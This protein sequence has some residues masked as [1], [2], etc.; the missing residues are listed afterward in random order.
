MH[1]SGASWETN[2]PTYI[3]FSHVALS[4]LT[5]NNVLLDTNVFFLSLDEEMT[6][7]KGSSRFD[8][9]QK[10]NTKTPQKHINMISTILIYTYRDT[11]K[12][13]RL[14]VSMQTTAAATASTA[15]R[16]VS[17]RADVM[18]VCLWRHRCPVCPGCVCRPE[19]RLS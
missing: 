8:F 5:R 2:E 4:L 11:A 1:I 3:A 18:V 17:Q 16:A 15:Q 9:G 6:S 19:S 7:H 14:T 12:I 13:E 10:T